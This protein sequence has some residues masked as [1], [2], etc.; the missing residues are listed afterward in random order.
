MADFRQATVWL[1]EGKKVRQKH[2]I[3]DAF[4]EYVSLHN[5][6][7]QH[8]QGRDYYGAQFLSM[9]D[10]LAEDWEIFDE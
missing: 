5:M 8:V 4:T 9:H 7:V 10:F 1:N 3:K 2:W 6:F